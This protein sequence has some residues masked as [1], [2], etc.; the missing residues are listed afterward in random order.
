MLKRRM[1]L[2]LMATVLRLTV[3]VSGATVEFMIDLDGQQAPTPSA[4]T[5]E[6][7]VILDTGSGTLDWTV[8]FDAAAL[9]DGAASVTVA[10][11]HLGAPGVDG[12]PVSPPGNVGGTGSSPMTGSAVVDADAVKALMAGKVYF[13][14]HTTAFPAGEI[15][16]Q[17]VPLKVTLEASRDNTLYEDSAG[18]RS[19]GS[20][21]HLFAGRSQDG[22][23]KRALIHFDVAASGIPA[24]S[25]IN[26][27]VLS[28]MM[29]RSRAGSETVELRAVRQDWGEGTS[30][31]GGNEGRGTA[32]GPGDATWIH[33][34]H[35]TQRWESPGGDFAERVSASETVFST[36]RYQWGPAG[37]MSDDVQLWLD[38]SDANFGWL[39]LGNEQRTQSTK[40]FDSREHPI[41]ANRPRLELEYGPPCPFAL[42]GDV[43]RDCRVDFADLAALATSWLIDCTTLPLDPAC[44]PR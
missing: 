26:A 27:A 9:T 13:N 14:I 19:N 24:G 38:E 36:G 32:A 6:G 7:T 23:R 40:R 16:G 30:N 31:A 18:S 2:L 10:H 3:T 17:V 11:F 44:V 42:A 15:R 12:P 29:S 39:L 25:T 33:T 43:N 22:E 34:F 20:G 5:G 8:T 21:Q 35:D 37:H 1:S 28:M 41:E 4:A